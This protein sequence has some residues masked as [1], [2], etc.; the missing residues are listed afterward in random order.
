MKKTGL[1]ELLFVA[2]AFSVLGQSK[3]G[4]ASENA[5]LIEQMTPFIQTT[6]E[7]AVREEF[8]EA[9]AGQKSEDDAEKQAAALQTE[10][11]NAVRQAIRDEFAL[12]TSGLDGSNFAFPVS[13]TGIP[14][15]SIMSKGII[16][17]DT[18][19]TFLLRKN[20]GLSHAEADSLV[21]IYIREAEAEGV[22]Y[23]IA[24]AQMCYHTNYLSFRAVFSPKSA[25][26]FC[27]ISDIY[28][29]SGAYKFKDIP[30]GIRAH[31]Q[32]RQAYAG[33]VRTKN[34][35]VDPRY[36]LVLKQYGQGSAPT[37]DSLAAK[38]SPSNPRYALEIKAI[39]AELYAFNEAK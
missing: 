9:A 19:I 39:L 35:V 29:Y 3:N 8:S 16:L 23:E 6:A 11:V 25:N 34:F 33:A 2:A 24:F 20:P 30:T 22:N 28:P 10:I 13:K 4:I 27:G 5:A 7:E 21:T 26:N 38:W 12:M 31:I 36:E 15:Q 14:S 1:I 18:M 32:H 37:I 17:P